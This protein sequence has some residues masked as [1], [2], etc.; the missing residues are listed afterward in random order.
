MTTEDIAA[1]NRQNAQS[2]TGPRSPHGKAKVAANARRHGATARPDP[3]DIATWLAIILDTPEI[4][5]AALMPQDDRGARAISLARAE[6]RCVATERALQDFEAEATKP[7]DHAT[8][9][10]A[11]AKDVAAQ[12]QASA[13][14]GQQQQ[15]VKRL[16]RQRHRTLCQE[17]VLGS[18]RHRLLQR[19]FCEAQ[20]QRGKARAAW[21]AVRDGQGAKA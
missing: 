20:A 14:K 15:L 9:L 2:S 17:S 18:K 4:T 7:P 5:P 1:R 12:W 19:Y 6:A 8:S 21:L 13:D 16:I 3:T 10:A 11:V